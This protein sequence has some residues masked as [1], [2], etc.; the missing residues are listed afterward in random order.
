MKEAFQDLG[1]I[2]AAAG[3]SSR[4]GEKNKL[5]LTLGKMPVFCHCLKNFFEYASPQA[6]ILCVSEENFTE[7]EN[8]LKIHLPE[9]FE[10]I[11][12]LSGG[13]SR[14]E[15]VLK[16]LRSLPEPCRYVAVQDAARPLSSAG[17]LL[18]C[19]ESAK[20]YGSGVAAKRLTDTVKMANEEDFAVKTLERRLL[21][22]TETPQVFEKKILLQ[23]YDKCYES[24]KLFVDD[25]QLLEEVGIPVKLVE[26]KELNNKITIF[27]D[28]NLISQIIV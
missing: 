19:L 15:T 1:L 6:T 14:S 27:A 2:V 5:L 23:A 17:L 24:E 8:L 25:A 21:W 28:F 22:H 26:N 12:L 4:F 20:K 9:I 3:S 10:K 18:K 11:S 16:A 7:F 13:S